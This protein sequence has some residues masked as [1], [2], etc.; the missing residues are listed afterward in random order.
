MI[1]VL[2]VGACGGAHVTLDD[3]SDV[4]TD[5]SPDSGGDTAD[6]APADTADTADAVDTSPIDSGR[7]DTGD[8]GADSAESIPSAPVLNLVGV[9]EESSSL[10][11]SFTIT[12]AD[13][14]IDGGTFDLDIDGAVSH[15]AISGGLASWDGL[16]GTA[17]VPFEPCD[18]GAAW[19]FS[20][21]A[22]DAS[23]LTSGASTTTATISGTSYTFAESGDTY[24]DALDLGVVSAGTYICGDIDRAIG[25][26]YYNGSDLDWLVFTPDTTARWTISLTW[27]DPTA[28]EDLSLMDDMTTTLDIANDHTAAQPEEAAYVLSTGETYYAWVGG[29]SLPATD[30]VVVFE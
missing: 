17:E 19:T 27:D 9:T 5:P 10:L 6:T 8:T 7:S 11:L 16:E 21:T 29:W 13:D 24:G 14:D 30:Y 1:L 20:A 22:T 23:G 26:E 2:F 28:D 4:A 3:S 25:H 12:D 18:H 15:Y